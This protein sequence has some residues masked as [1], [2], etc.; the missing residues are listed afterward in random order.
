MNREQAFLEAQIRY[1]KKINEQEKEI[2]ELKQRVKELE[3]FK[4]K[5]KSERCK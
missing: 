1:Q 4:E 2:S 5:H 3:E